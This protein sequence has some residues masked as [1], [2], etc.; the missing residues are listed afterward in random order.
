[1][2]RKKNNDLA[3]AATGAAMAAGKAIVGLPPGATAVAG[4]RPGALPAV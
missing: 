3:K 4:L 1:M 2:S